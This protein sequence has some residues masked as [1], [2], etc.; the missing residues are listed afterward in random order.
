[1]ILPVGL[2]FTILLVGFNFL[3]HTESIYS[4]LVLNYGIVCLGERY[5][6]SCK[7]ALVNLWLADDTVFYLLVL[8]IVCS[9]KE[10]FL[11][12]IIGGCVDKLFR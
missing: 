7:Q 11:H 12:R 9:L 3:L 4:P 5:S 6:V 10:R 2:F 1:M 8:C